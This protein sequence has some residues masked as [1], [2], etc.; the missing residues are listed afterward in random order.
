MAGEPQR[1]RLDPSRRRLL[2]SQTERH[3]AVLH[4]SISVSLF[5]RKLLDKR[6]EVDI[7]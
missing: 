4:P 2:I 5:V 3:L 1:I 7:L 6:G